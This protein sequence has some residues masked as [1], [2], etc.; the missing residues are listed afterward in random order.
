[1]KE[2]TPVKH[3]IV[4]RSRGELAPTPRTRITRTIPASVLPRRPVVRTVRAWLWELFSPP[5]PASFLSPSE[6]QLVN[7]RMHWL[8]PLRTIGQAT[9]AMP[10]AGLLL[11][12]LN[13]AA[14]T[15][16]QALLCLAAVFHQVWLG[17]VILRWRADHIIVTDKRL[18]RVSGIV[19]VT[20]DAVHL[21]EITDTTYH[22]SLIGRILNY[23]TLVVKSAGRSQSLERMDFVPSPAAINRATLPHAGTPA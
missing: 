1:M 20:V 4:P 5:P 23:G 15:W 2:G 22:R 11:W 6:H 3:D 8:V 18:I 10:L 16:L 9:I 19:N 14:P 17:Y 13:T 12:V 7:T 21:S